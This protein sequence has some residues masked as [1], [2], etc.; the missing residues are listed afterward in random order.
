LRLLVLRN[1]QPA[2][3]AGAVPPSIFAF[4]RHHHLKHDDLIDLLYNVQLLL[5][6]SPSRVL[7]KLWRKTDALMI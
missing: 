7:M 3:F 5:K 4:Y 6:T 1:N 2:N